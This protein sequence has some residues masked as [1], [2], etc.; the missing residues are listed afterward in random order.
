MFDSLSDVGRGEDA[1]FFLAEGRRRRAG[2]EPLVAWAAG[3]GLA[4]G[5]NACLS[6]LDEIA[7]LAADLDC[8]PMRADVEARRARLL[9]ESEAR[10]GALLQILPLARLMNQPR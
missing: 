3:V 9:V 10:K 8:A 6:W 7:R 2:D 1:T 4:W 5:I